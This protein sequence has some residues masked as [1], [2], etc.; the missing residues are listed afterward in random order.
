MHISD[1]FEEYASKITRIHLYQRAM[2]DLARGE[3][4]RLNEH[5]RL[6]EKS[7]ELKDLPSSHHNIYFRD[8][9][10]GAH[11]LLGYKSSSLEERQI[12]VLL[13]K[14]KQYQWLLAEAYEDFEDYLECA[15]AYAASKNTDYWP[16]SDFGSISLSELK[17]KHYEWFLSQA[18]SKKERP[19]S[20]LNQFRKKHPAICDIEKTN[21]F[22]IN[23]RLALTLIE[24]L[25]HVIVHHGGV[26]ENKDKFRS[27]VLKKTG[28]L[29]NGIP[30]EDNTNFINSFFG[31]GIYETTVMLLEI[32]VHKD[33]PLDIHVGRF[34]LL[35]ECLISYADVVKNL[36]GS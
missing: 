26:I 16:L 22:Q 3:L 12:S 10:T 24:Q 5:A 23:M 21:K 15:Y 27:D 19:H 31:T 25:R 28:L 34:D 4:V 13:H 2:N 14:N 20:I 32:R 8:A 35:S 11:R 1:I 30:H 36:L 7:S 33:I 6:I 9:V 18:K 17:S 29:N